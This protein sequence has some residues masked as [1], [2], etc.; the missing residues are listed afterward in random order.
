VES[1]ITE[2]RLRDGQVR[3]SGCLVIDGKAVYERHYD[4]HPGKT[5]QRLQ[6]FFQGIG[7]KLRLHPLVVMGGP[8]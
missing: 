5:L 8:N 2:V 7:G 1:T 6:E 3:W 4:L